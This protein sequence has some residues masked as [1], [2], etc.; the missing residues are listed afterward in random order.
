MRMTESKLRRLIRS[1][2]SESMEFAEEDVN[3]DEK[4]KEDK[5]IKE[6]CL[7]VIKHYYIDNNHKSDAEYNAFIMKWCFK[8]YGPD[9]DKIKKMTDI[10]KKIIIVKS[11]EEF[12]QAPN[13]HRMSG[14]D[15]VT[16]YIQTNKVSEQIKNGFFIKSRELLKDAEAQ[17]REY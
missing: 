4:K 15:S 11:P 13:M 12:D 3:L 5:D 10:M 16:S 1:V 14:I 17:A 8:K 6:L 7:A 2:I 9:M